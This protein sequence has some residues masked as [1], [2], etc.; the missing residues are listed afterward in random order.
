M[1]FKIERNDLTRMEVDA[2]VNAANASLLMGG[3]VCGAI[4]RAAGAR[5]LQEACNVLAPIK[6][7]EAV[8]TPGFR[9]PAKFII[10]AV[11]PVY[12]RARADECEQ[13]LR[14]AY[15]NSLRL[16]ADKGCSSIAFPL[17]SSGIFGYPKDEALNVAVSAITDFLAESDDDMDV[18]LT[19]FDKSSYV[20]SR[21]LAKDIESYVDENYVKENYVDYG[22][23][24]MG[25]PVSMRPLLDEEKSVLRKAGRKLTGV[26]GGVQ[27]E[28][29]ANEAMPDEECDAIAFEDAMISEAPVNETAAG[30]GKGAGPGTARSDSLDDLIGNLDEPFT[31]TL[32]RLI[33]AKGMDDVT[34]YKNANIDRKLFSK[35]RSNDYY[36]PSKKTAIA[37]A[38]S[39][40]LN[41]EETQDLLGRAGFALSHADKFDVFIEYFIT[42]G[43]YNIHEINQILFSYDLPILSA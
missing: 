28:S 17:I 43:M 16:A 9:L 37:F 35:I 6:T 41:L 18:T 40:K 42:H 22:V 21:E 32:F 26:F 12:S 4:F 19:V 3:G 2:I 7:G 34:V 10:H 13:E 31:K 15:T 27:P 24:N 1:P 5:D 30:A 23:D 29:V 36:K 11:G 14:N 39:L 25:N 33:D 20:I 8:I 38:V